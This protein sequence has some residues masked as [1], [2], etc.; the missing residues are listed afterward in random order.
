MHQIPAIHFGCSIV[1]GKGNRLTASGLRYGSPI[2]STIAFQQLP[3]GN[4]LHG[5][6]QLIPLADFCRDRPAGIIQCIIH[7][8]IVPCSNVG[9]IKCADHSAIT[10][11]NLGSCGGIENGI[12]RCV[13]HGKPHISRIPDQTEIA[14]KNA[15]A[16]SQCVTIF[17]ICVVHGVRIAAQIDLRIGVIFVQLR[18]H[19]IS[20]CC[21]PG[22]PGKVGRQLFF[23]GEN[24]R[25]GIMVEHR[26]TLPIAIE[27]KDGDAVRS[28]NLPFGVSQR[29]RLNICFY[30]S[31]I[32]INGIQRFLRFLCQGNGNG[33]RCFAIGRYGNRTAGEF[34]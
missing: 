15:A 24:L 34:L 25:T 14:A 31:T 23:A 2:H 16:A 27:G 4:R 21:L 1:N 6:C 7:G 9:V 11:V 17:Q 26:R 32:G 29:F 19:R 30:I 3:L 20:I 10:A 13:R 8:C 33:N 5:D 28:C 22:N 12:V 18:N